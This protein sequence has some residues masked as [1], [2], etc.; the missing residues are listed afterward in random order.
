MN[1]GRTGRMVDVACVAALVAIGL[2]VWS[3]VS[4]KPLPVFLAMSAGQAVGTLS[5][6]LF[7]AALVMSVASSSTETRT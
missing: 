3:V 5:L 1:R 2:M 7:L 4:P 6:L